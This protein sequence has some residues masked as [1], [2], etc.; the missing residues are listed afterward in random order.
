[1][2]HYLFDREIKAAYSLV[3][4]DAVVVL[5]IDNSSRGNFLSHSTPVFYFR[6][7]IWR[8]IL[9]SFVSAHCRQFACNNNR[10]QQPLSE[11]VPSKQLLRS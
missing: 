9:L 2:W 6:T 11:L 3:S 7:R 1:M 5:D 10:S 4:Y 8:V